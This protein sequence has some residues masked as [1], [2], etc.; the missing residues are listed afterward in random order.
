MNLAFTFT[1]FSSPT[2]FSP[3]FIFTTPLSHPKTNYSG[4]SPPPFL[5]IYFHAPLLN[6]VLFFIHVG[7]KSLIFGVQYID[8]HIESTPTT[9]AIMAS[10]QGIQQVN[11]NFY[12]DIEPYST[13][14]LKV[15]D[16]HSIYW[17]QSGNPTGHVSI[18]CY[19]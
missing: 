11:P 2:K 1:P 7:R 6:L 18:N 3:S 12:P 19:H 16:L 13:G 10:Q 4:K 8:N 15:S 5:S 17:E 9:T 14:F